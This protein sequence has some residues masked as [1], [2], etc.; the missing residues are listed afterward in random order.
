MKNNLSTQLD[1]YFKVIIACSNFKINVA[2]QSGQDWSCRIN[3]FEY[4]FSSSMSYEKRR[5]YA[6]AEL[7]ITYKYVV[8]TEEYLRSKQNLLRV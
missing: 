7:F 6:S 5:G 2:R 8:E 3:S 4:A 1:W